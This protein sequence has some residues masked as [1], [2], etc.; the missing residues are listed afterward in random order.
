LRQKI[1]ELRRRGRSYNEIANTLGIYKSRISYLVGKDA[2]SVVVKEKLTARNVIKSRKRMKNLAHKVRE[3]ME[4]SD[5][6]TR[7]EARMSFQKLVSDP[8]FVAGIMLYWGEG[9]NKS[10]NHLR[11]T[12]TD[13]RMIS[14][15]VRFVERILLVPKDKISVG[16]ILYP[17]LN[18]KK[19][20]NFWSKI[21]RLPE[22]R[23]MKSQYIQGRHPTRRLS[24]GI[25]MIVVSNTRQKI[26]VMEWIDLFQKQFK[27]G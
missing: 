23:F 19:C 16:L 9:D 5:E 27:M 1:L 8:L 22:N 21:T 20:K 3:V 13:P 12:N 14:L 11:L 7:K 2:S 10:R 24:W 17:D 26:K 15:Y 18:D 6:E 4:K 25:C